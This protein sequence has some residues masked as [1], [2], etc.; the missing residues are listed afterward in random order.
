MGRVV[1]TGYVATVA[2]LTAY[3]FSDA[4]QD[5]WGAEIAAAVLTLPAVVAAL[6]A[7]YLLGA[8]AWTV[9][10]AGDSGPMWPVTLAFTL[11]M[12]AVACGNAAGFVLLHRVLRRKEPA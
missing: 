1:V 4:H 6:P 5:H 3:A 11:L 9:S 7:I 10:D 2:A 12:S 8:A